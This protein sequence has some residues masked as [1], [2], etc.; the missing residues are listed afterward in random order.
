MA[1]V[2]KEKDRARQATTGTGA[3]YVLATS[4]AAIV[5][6]FAVVYLLFFGFP[7]GGGI[8]RPADPDSVPPIELNRETPD[9]RDPAPVQPLPQTPQ[10]PA[11]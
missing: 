8:D 2:E 6:L 5:V 9:W 10:D 4:L 11:P 1:G 3:R 7:G